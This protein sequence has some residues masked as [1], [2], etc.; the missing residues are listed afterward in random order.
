[1][2]CGVLLQLLD[3]LQRDSFPVKSDQRAARC[4]GTALSVATGLLGA[5]VPGTGARI[6]AFVGGPCTEGS[7]TV[8]VLSIPK[9]YTSQPPNWV[10]SCAVINL[11]NNEAICLWVCVIVELRL[12]T[13]PSE[14]LCCLLSVKRD[15]IVSIF[16]EWKR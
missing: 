3:E 6:L 12:F 13:T 14:S 16:S 1:M 2:L 9:L 8:R 15:Q 10:S 5:C 11:H 7:G 4:T